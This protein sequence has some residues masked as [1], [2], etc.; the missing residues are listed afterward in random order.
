MGTYIPEPR[1]SF[2]DG[3]VTVLAQVPQKTEPEAK[4]SDENPSE[5]N[6]VPR[7]QEEE[8]KGNKN[9]E[10]K[11]Q[12]SHGTVLRWPLHRQNSGCP[13]RHLQRQ[14]GHCMSQQQSIGEETGRTTPPP[15]PSNLLFLTGQSA[16]CGT[17]DPHVVHR[18]T[19]SQWPQQ[20]ET[21]TLPNNDLGQG[22]QRHAEVSM[23]S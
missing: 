9:G 17:L 11:K 22:S 2:Q 15:A 3:H 20:H 5:K 23:M 18:V 8:T 16:S 19:A 6:V 10:H 13:G 1:N 7:D 14:C 12:Q 4:N 21:G